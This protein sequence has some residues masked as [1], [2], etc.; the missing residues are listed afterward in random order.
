MALVVSEVAVIVVVVFVVLVVVVSVRLDVAYVVV[1]L[2]AAVVV[3]GCGG[4]CRLWS[5]WSVGWLCLWLCDFCV[6][7]EVVLRFV[8]AYVAVAVAQQCCW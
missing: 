4:G 2:A 3:V 5:W 8:I 7:G 6:C 1:A